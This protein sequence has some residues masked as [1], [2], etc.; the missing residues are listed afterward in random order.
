MKRLAVAA[1]IL[2]GCTPTEPY[3]GKAHLMEA[4][5]TSPIE[6][7]RAPL[8]ELLPGGTLTNLPSG[9]IRLAIDRDVTFRE[10]QTAL[11]AMKRAGAVP[12]LLVERRTYVEQI[13]TWEAKP[14]GDAILLKAQTQGKACVAPPDAI[15]EVPGQ[16]T[17]VAR[18][19][20]LH[21][22]RA[23]VRQTLDQAVKEYKLKKIHVRIDP[24][25][26]WADA[27][28]AIDGART[29]CG[30]LPDLEVTVE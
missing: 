17:C 28:R 4:D 6:A 21:I 9:P 20:H 13:A 22:D 26:T 27:V 23:F 8:L 12:I 19:D 3:S 5:G 10:V 15:A 1:V 25:L 16:S 14:T 29:C 24:T 7:G 11:D 18:Q 2:L 30:D